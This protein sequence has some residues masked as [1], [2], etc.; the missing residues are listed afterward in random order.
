MASS[1]TV[2]IDGPLRWANQPAC[3]NVPLDVFFCSPTDEDAV[4]YAKSFCALCRAR[5]E[6]LEF[7]L[8]CERRES[9]GEDLGIFGGLTYD[10][11][12]SYR[13]NRRKVSL[14]GNV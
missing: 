13:R 2:S 11:R 4:A 12:R 8:S 9:D 3:R 10:E 5:Q 14:P 7:A 6:C 1:A